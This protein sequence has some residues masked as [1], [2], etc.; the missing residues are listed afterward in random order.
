LIYAVCDIDEVIRIIRESREREEAIL[1]LMEHAFRITP[2]HRY[3]PLIPTRVAEASRVGDGAL[4]TRVQA[5][6][7]GAMRL[8]QLV[9]LEVEKLAAEFSKVLEDID[10]L[11]SILADEKRV[12][13]IVRE[14]VLELKE[15][16][17]DE[18]RTAIEQGEAEDFEMADLIPEHEVVVTISHAGWVKRLPADAYRTQGRGGVGVRGSDAKDGDFIEQ[19]FTG[20]SH[21]DLLCFTTTGRVFRMKTWQ[22]PEM[23]RTSKGRAIQNLIELRDGETVQTFLSVSNFETREDFLFFVTREGRVKRTALQDFRNVNKSGIIALKLNDNDHLVNVLLTSGKND[24]LLATAQGL[25]IRFDENDA[26]VMG[27]ATAGV[28]GMT[29]REDDYIVGAVRCD[30]DTDLL[31]ATV[32]GYGKRTSLNEYMVQ[33]DDGTTRCQSRGGKGRYDIKTEGRNGLV[34][35]VRAVTAA[36]QLM[37]LSKEGMVVRIPATAISQIGRNTMGVRIMRLGEGDS[38]MGVALV[39]EV[40]ETILPSDIPPVDAPPE[41]LPEIPP[42]A[43]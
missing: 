1:S 43:E 15:K 41:T 40:D 10:G 22:I 3:A 11:E 32:N 37:L 24:V 2:D 27:R 6:A 26:R 35:S 25:A 19:I 34:V 17:G 38:L 12:L 8:I 16:F 29:L 33:Q 13:D 36:D 39:A 31:T 18:R 20:S 5:E 7:I 4:L 42:A 28:N 23:S 14:D 21:D 30:P 9:G